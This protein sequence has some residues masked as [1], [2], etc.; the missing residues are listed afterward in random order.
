MVNHDAFD[1][2]GLVH[3]GNV[4]PRVPVWLNR[5][6]FNADVRITTGFVD[7]TSS[8]GSAVDRKW[9]RQVSPDSPQRCDSMML[10]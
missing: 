4:E 3:V 9:S 10:R 8:P 7:H 2:A 6:W 1:E 5:R